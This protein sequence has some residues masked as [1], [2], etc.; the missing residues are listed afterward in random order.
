MMAL[1]HK[2]KCLADIDDHSESA[3]R[4]PLRCRGG[5]VQASSCQLHTVDIGCLYGIL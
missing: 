3:Y 1:D 2:G 5:D 4:E